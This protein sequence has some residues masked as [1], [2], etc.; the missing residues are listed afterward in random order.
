MPVFHRDGL[1]RRSACPGRRS[2][3]LGAQDRLTLSE[4]LWIPP[5]RVRMTSDRDQSA[6]S[7]EIA[8]RLADHHVI[9][10][11][12][13]P[14]NIGQTLQ[15]T[16]TRLSHTLRDA[17][18]VAGCDALLSRALSRTESRHPALKDVR[19]TDGD[20]IHLDGVLASIDAHGAPAVTVAIEA[21]L[22]ALAEILGRLIGEEMAT[23]LIGYEASPAR[24][25]G[26]PQA[27]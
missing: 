9:F 12:D 20:G 15:H 8:R 26:G 6:A 24:S 18:G 5:S 10:A 1:R 4:L 25:G 17:M 11:R 2:T 22:A 13:G 19:R 14:A 3:G 27:P 21:F 23:Q 16:C 7:R